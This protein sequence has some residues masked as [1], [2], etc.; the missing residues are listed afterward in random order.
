MPPRASP[1]SCRGMHWTELWGTVGG[2]GRSVGTVGR[3]RA[4]LFVQWG[5]GQVCAGTGAGGFGNEGGGEERCV[6]QKHPWLWAFFPRY[7]MWRFGRKSRAFR[8]LG[9]TFSP[10]GSPGL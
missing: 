4:D 5:S 2:Q 1:E 10:V 9:T 8:L 3:V 6:P 7:K